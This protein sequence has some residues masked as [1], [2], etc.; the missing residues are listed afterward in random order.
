MKKIGLFGGTFDPI[1]LGHLMLALELQE[2]CAL[3]EV[4]FIPAKNPALRAETQSAT[5]EERLEMVRLAIEGIPGFFLN[6]IEMKREGVSYTIDTLRE[7]K[8]R[9]PEHQFFLLMGEDVALGFPKW[10]ES[11]E[12]LQEIP[13]VVGARSGFEMQKKILN[14]DFPLKIRE[15]VM[16]GIY[17]TKLMDIEGKEIRKRLKERLYCGHLLPAKVLDYIYQNQLYF[18]A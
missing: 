1:H 16:K 7:L 17:S 8:K 9:H 18:N 3:S 4:W 11:L 12:I 13:L 14:L 15:A 10:K 2:K 6:E 5:P